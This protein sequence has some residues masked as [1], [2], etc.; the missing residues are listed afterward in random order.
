MAY[1]RKLDESRADQTSNVESNLHSQVEEDELSG[2]MT[3]QR[4]SAKMN[5]NIYNTNLQKGG[6]SNAFFD[7]TLQS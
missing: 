1:Y 5:K 6:G 2:I 3:R 7:A 4:T